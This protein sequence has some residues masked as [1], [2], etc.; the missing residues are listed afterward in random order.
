MRRLE[1]ALLHRPSR[2]MAA[3]Q[4]VVRP[5]R[6]IRRRN[7]GRDISRRP[8]GALA[9]VETLSRLTIWVLFPFTFLLLAVYCLIGIHFVSQTLRAV[10]LYVESHC[11]ACSGYLVAVKFS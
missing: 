3:S 1:M 4:R 6:T 2:L 11:V 10:T 8:V 7:S 9:D 5:S